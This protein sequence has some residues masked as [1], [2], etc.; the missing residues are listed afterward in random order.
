MTN[1][2]KRWGLRKYTARVDD[3]SASVEPSPSAP[4]AFSLLTLPPTSS[5]QG[6]ILTGSQFPDLPGDPTAEN[7]DIDTDGDQCSTGTVSTL[8]KGFDLHPDPGLI[9]LLKSLDTKVTAY[10]PASVH[11]RH[12]TIGATES[13]YEDGNLRETILRSLA[14]IPDG[15][16]QQLNHTSALRHDA[17]MISRDWRGDEVIG[18]WNGNSS[19]NP[20]HPADPSGFDSLS[21]AAALEQED[22]TDDDFK[23]WFNIPSDDEKLD[24]TLSM[25]SGDQY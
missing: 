21:F 2:F 3:P 6:F 23:S 17:G 16:L 19:P 15:D 14:G 13:E 8:L 4:L 24:A 9:Q 1:Q 11:P 20:P 12:D 25:K 10:R 7:I 5:N 22:D 18:S